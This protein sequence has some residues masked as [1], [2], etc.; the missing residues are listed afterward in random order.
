MSNLADR[1]SALRSRSQ[2]IRDVAE[3]DGILADV[4]EL[5]EAL[6]PMTDTSYT[7]QSTGCGKNWIRA[8]DAEILRAR[9]ILT[10]TG[11]IKGDV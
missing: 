4:R 5:Q 1:I 3:W 10:K 2:R 9:T 11:A 6:S 8:S 7:P